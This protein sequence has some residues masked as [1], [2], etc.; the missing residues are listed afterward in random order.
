MAKRRMF[1]KD[2]ITSDAFL[3]MPAST[4]NLYFYLSMEA[5]DDGFVNKPLA[6]MRTIGG[7]KD[8]MNL[9]FHKKFIIDCGDGIVVIKHWRIHNYIAKDRYTETKYKEKKEQL[10][11]DENKAYTTKKSGLYT[12]CIQSV[13]SGKVRI[14]EV[15]IDK[16][17]EDILAPTS[18]EGE[19][20]CEV[21]KFFIPLKSGSFH[22]ITDD[23][24]T[25]YKKLFPNIDIEQE[26]RNM[27]AWSDANPQKRKTERGV[28]KFIASWLTRTQG[29]V[30]AAPES[31]EEQTAR[32]FDDWGGTE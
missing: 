7:G 20:D 8:D 12:A 16:D 19:A 23:K 18:I 5:D 24:L 17:R 29:Q 10:I 9:L 14:G 1:S 22:S 27:I 21:V 28:D 15:S 31:M 3:D 2:I 11:L 30:K 32:M 13:D 4:R 26:F 25:E 6:I